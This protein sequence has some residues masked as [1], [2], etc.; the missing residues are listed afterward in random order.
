MRDILVNSIYNFWYVIWTF[1]IFMANVF[2][3]TFMIF[4]GFLM[5]IYKS[6]RGKNFNDFKVRN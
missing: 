4:Y 3:Q 1:V 6:C 5:I 2:E